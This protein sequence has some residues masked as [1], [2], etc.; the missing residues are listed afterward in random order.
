MR[1]RLREAA[2]E[3]G[4]DVELSTLEGSTR[5]SAEAAAAL[6]CDPHLV[7]KSIVFVADGDPIVCVAA[8]THRIDI[9]SLCD[10]VDCAEVRQATPSE[11]RAAV[12]FPVG[13]VPAF[14]HG[15]P[16]V[17]DEALLEQR[18]I[19]AAG[20][21]GHTMCALDPREL[22]ARTGATVAPVAG[23]PV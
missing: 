2:R 20:G 23:V 11:V 21:D 18:L 10:A 17:I 3:L 15:L 5:T 16:I 19:W 4:L 13:G 8:G 9:D 6:G 7:A 14:G 1:E 22:V 12:S